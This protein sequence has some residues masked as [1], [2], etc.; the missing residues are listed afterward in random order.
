MRAKQLGLCQ[1]VATLNFFRFVLDQMWHYR[2]SCS[3]ASSS[4]VG[5]CVLIYRLKAP[6]R[7]QKGPRDTVHAHSYHIGNSMHPCLFRAEGV[8][9]GMSWLLDLDVRGTPSSYGGGPL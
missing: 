4:S 1:K 7:R 8:H 6:K 2:V 9:F 5:A 3:R